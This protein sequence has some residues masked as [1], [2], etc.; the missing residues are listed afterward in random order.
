MSAFGG[1]ADIA[2]CP[3]YPQK[4]TLEL[5][6]GMSALCQKRTLVRFGRQRLQD[7]VRH[8]RA[9]NALERKLADRLD[10]YGLLDGLPNARANE[11]LSWLGFF[12]KPGGDIGYRSDR[13]IVVA[14][15]KSNRAQRRKTMCYADPEAKVMAKIAPFLNHSTD[16]GAHINRHQNRL[17]CRVFY[18]DRIIEN[19]HHAVA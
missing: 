16:C 19:H 15:L 6:R 8:Y 17:E 1:I 11:N 14:T 4:R 13:G 7:V 2:A 18:R 3:L 5:S 10:R 12:A 9:A